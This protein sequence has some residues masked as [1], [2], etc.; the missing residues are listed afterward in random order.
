MTTW[1]YKEYKE[2]V[3]LGCL[4]NETVTH[5]DLTDNNLASIPDEIEKLRNLT[6]L[7]LGRNKLTSIP[8]TIGQLEELI[9]LNL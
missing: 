9:E 3:D 7:L 8:S 5:L 6:C 4:E 1:H 2:W